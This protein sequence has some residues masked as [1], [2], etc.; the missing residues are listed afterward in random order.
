V[1]YPPKVSVSSLVN[2][3]KGVSSYV[4]RRQLP[5]QVLLE[6]CVVVA[7][8]LC[9]I[10]WRR[11]AR[12]NQTL[13]RAAGDTPIVVAYPGLKSGACTTHSG[14]TRAAEFWI[15]CVN[16]AV[17]LACIYCIVMVTTEDVE[18]L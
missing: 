6:E 18:L 16:W 14:S 15:P 13:H 8:L 5:R 7:V 17:L 1:N 11:A 12:G 4:L 9:R 2:S 10:L 3:L